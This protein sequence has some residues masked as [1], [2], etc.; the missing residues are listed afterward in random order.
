MLIDTLG[1]YSMHPLNYILKG[2]YKVG[3]RR[4]KIGEQSE[5]SMDCAVLARFASLATVRSRLASLT[6]FFTL[7]PT[8]EPAHMLV[9]TFCFVLPHHQPQ[10]YLLAA[11]LVLRIKASLFWQFQL[12]LRKALLN[13]WHP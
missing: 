3:Y 11:A 2:S 5:P 13:Q 1:L 9:L 4:K 8:K 7:Y 6:D 10:A 12:A